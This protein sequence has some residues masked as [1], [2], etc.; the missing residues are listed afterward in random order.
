MLRPAQFLGAIS[1]I[2]LEVDARSVFRSGPQVDGQS[3]LGDQSCPAQILGATVTILI[4][5]RLDTSNYL[6]NVDWI[7]L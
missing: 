1:S 2:H 5:A 4:A 7:L 6:G 3:S